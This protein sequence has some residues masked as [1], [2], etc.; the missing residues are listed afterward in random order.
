MS[1]DQ[2][3]TYLN[4]VF[5]SSIYNH[6]LK[7]DKNM[8]S[9]IDFCVQLTDKTEGDIQKSI[10][11]I[12]VNFSTILTDLP[13]LQPILIEHLHKKC[14]SETV[15]HYD[16]TPRIIETLS[17]SIPNDTIHF[18]NIINYLG[19]E[20]YEM[21]SEKGKEILGTINISKKVDEI[22]GTTNF[23]EENELFTVQQSEGFQ[24]MLREENVDFLSS[25]HISDSSKTT[26][27]KK[28]IEDLSHKEK[29]EMIETLIQ[30]ISREGRIPNL[31]D[32]LFLPAYEDPNKKKQKELKNYVTQATAL[33][34]NIIESPE[35]RIPIFIQKLYEKCRSNF[36]RDNNLT[37]EIIE[38]IIDY[39]WFSEGIK[40]ATHYIPNELKE[41]MKDKPLDNLSYH[42]KREI[43]ERIIQ[44][45]LQYENISNI[46]HSLF[47]PEV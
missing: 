44:T 42:L 43:I 32:S 28:V 19:D 12:R 22:L 14:R 5:S 13:T 24:R 20:L 16:L 47:L 31:P 18:S 15:R 11:N 2:F 10:S 8:I 35:F 23:I 33:Y 41:K 27:L 6:K 1:R 39:L 3:K 36:V 34:I 46:P 26:V 17:K 7:E 38:K 29:K 30:N 40:K 37:K 4:S 45:I 9:E 21:I 25:D